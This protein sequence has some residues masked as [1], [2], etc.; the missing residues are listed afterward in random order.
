VLELLLKVVEDLCKGLLMKDFSLLDLEVLI[1][2][3]NGLLISDRIQI[4]EQHSSLEVL[5][6][7]MML[8]LIEL[9]K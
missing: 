4:Q 3:H 9:Y 1:K 6:Q 7:H 5:Q 8:L 2:L